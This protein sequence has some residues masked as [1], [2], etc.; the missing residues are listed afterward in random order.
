MPDKLP[1]LCD[2]RF[3]HKEAD[4]TP[5]EK[6]QR[7][8]NIHVK[9]CCFAL[10]TQSHRLEPLR[11]RII[12]TQAIRRRNDRRHQDAFLFDAKPVAQVFVSSRPTNNKKDWLVQCHWDTSSSASSS[13]TVTPQNTDRSYNP[14]SKPSRRNRMSFTSAS[15][16]EKTDSGPKAKETRAC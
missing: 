12:P 13:R 2:K 4:W 11:I 10:K 5:W 16:V 3:R 15:Q 1:P 6:Q 14:K 8:P 7:V 9:A